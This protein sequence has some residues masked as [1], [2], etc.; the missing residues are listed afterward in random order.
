M[1][2]FDSKSEW[3]VLTEVLLAYE[4]FRIEEASGQ[5][6]MGAPIGWAVNG[7]S[8][9]HVVWR[10]EKASED[11]D[12]LTLL[13]RDAFGGVATPIGRVTTA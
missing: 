13:I 2:I 4:L 3:P 1:K 12:S 5:A 6:G 9:Q 7:L 8:D 11:D 10:T